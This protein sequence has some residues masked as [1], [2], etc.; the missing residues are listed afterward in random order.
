MAALRGLPA[1]REPGP[2][3]M[4]SLVAQDSYLQ[5]LARKVC[6][7]RSPEPRKRKFGNG[8]AVLGLPSLPA[9]LRESGLG[10]GSP[11]RCAWPEAVRRAV[12]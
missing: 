7:E 6:V 11:P 8:A 3:G 12:F 10:V 4:A 9:G 5:A 2:P 1:L